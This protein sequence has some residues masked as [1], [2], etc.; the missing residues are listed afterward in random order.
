M[1]TAEKYIKNLDVRQRQ[2]ALTIKII[3]VSLTKSDI[4]N[5]VFELRNGNTRII[6]NSGFGLLRVNFDSR[7]SWGVA[8]MSQML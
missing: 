2:V 1:K 7:K 4:K 3:D 6:N 5:N 8:Q